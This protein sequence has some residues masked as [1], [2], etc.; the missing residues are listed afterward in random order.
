MVLGVGDSIYIYVYIYSLY[1]ILYIY[2]IQRSL[3][4]LSCHSGY[5]QP[6]LGLLS[7]VEAVTLGDN[8]SLS[9]IGL[10]LT[11]SEPPHSSS[12]QLPAHT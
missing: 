9:L 6:S 11:H 7:S 10:S 5:R 4:C 12:G 3:T 1:I 8:I 2:Y